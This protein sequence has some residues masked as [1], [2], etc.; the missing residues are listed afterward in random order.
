[1]NAHVEIWD[2]DLAFKIPN[3]PS[4]YLFRAARASVT[5]PVRGFTASNLSMLRSSTSKLSAGRPERLRSVRRSVGGLPLEAPPSPCGSDAAPSPCPSLT[6]LADDSDEMEAVRVM[7]RVRPLSGRERSSTAAPAVSL[8]GPRTVVLTDPLR[9]ESVV[10]SYDR[11]FGPE[12][13]QEEVFQ[14][15]GLPAVEHCLAGFNA[16]IFAYGQT[17][18]GKTHTMQGRAETDPET[19]ALHADCGM[20]LRV[21]RELFAKMRGAAA[22][23]SAA[24]ASSSATEYDVSIS[25]VEIYNEEVTDLL[26]PS[27]GPLAVRDGGPGGGVFVQDLSWHA[28]RSAAD[29]LELARRGS[30]NRRIAATQMNERSSRSH[31]VFTCRVTAAERAGGVA[32]TR[33][34]KLHLIDLAGSERVARSGA[35]G[36]QLAEAR[37]INRSLTVLGRVVSAL[38]DRARR[39]G[40]HVPYRD[41]RLTFLLQDSLGGNSRTAVVACVTPAVDSAAET[42]GTLLFASGVK[43]IRNRAVVNE[44]RACDVASL[45]AENAR[46]ARLVAE[47][48][49]RASD[50]EGARSDAEG[51]VL[52][53]T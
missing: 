23:G 46:L 31:S 47:L 29:A 44:D 13:P 17:G 6:S 2:E 20:T 38:A 26:S 7:V 30:E 50:N 24:S 40:T 5:P 4:N 41:S 10:R 19:G 51:A 34:S 33:A 42:L 3:S 35:E 43:R 25:F 15:V 36:Q 21:F 14:A 48:Q 39:P 9:A 37:S 22:E 49:A 27:S 45:R 18:A 8:S 32:V 28:V 16:A 12:A 1:M 11:V 52:A 53:S